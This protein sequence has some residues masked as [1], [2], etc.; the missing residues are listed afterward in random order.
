MSGK[1]ASEFCVT[2]LHQ[3]NSGTFEICWISLRSV[4]CV[5]LVTSW[6]TIPAGAAQVKDT[7]FSRD[8]GFFS[9]PFLVEI[10]TKTSE[11]DIFY[12]LDGSV[13][14]RKNGTRYQTALSI[15]T[16][17]VLRAAA[18]KDG[19]K[20]TNVDTMTYIFPEHVFKQS[21]QGLSST[22]GMRNE[23]PVVA[24][25]GMDAEITQSAVYRDRMLR[26]FESLPIVSLVLDK[27]DWLDAKH[28]I[29]ANPMERGSNWER[30]ASLEMIFP[31]TAND[32]LRQA[33]R[34]FQVN[35]GL[36]IQGG[37]N[38]RPEESP[39]HSLRLL[40]KKKYGPSQLRHPLFS[41]PTSPRDTAEQQKDVKQFK[42][43]IL[44]GGNNNTWLHRSSDERARGDYLRDQ[45]MRDTFAAMGHASARGRFVHLFLNG[46]YWGLYNLT[47]RPSAPWLASH[48]GGSADD[49]DARNSNKVLAG[50]N[51][52]WEALMARVNA[53][54]VSKESYA[55]VCDRLD[56]VN[57]A[58]YMLLNLYGANA[59]YDSS[60]NWYA[61]RPR[62]AGGKFRFFVWDGER[63][64][65]DWKRNAID[66]D[67]P[68]SPPHIFQKLRA[69]PTFRHLFANRAKLHCYGNGVL[70]S[71][72]TAA[73]FSFLAQ[74]IEHAMVIESA[75][76]GDY[77]RDVHSHETGPFELYTVD[78]FWRVEVN[79]LLEEYFPKR[80]GT[81]V[82]QLR[83]AGFE[84]G[85]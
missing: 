44:R 80:T 10:S 77:R 64:N 3:N 18:F 68:N 57:F 79:R 71:H 13:P 39:K 37:W 62:I 9:Q 11:A 78:D 58:D 26:G 76:W 4:S 40:F 1:K 48:F 7:K 24:D 52:A 61:G 32:Q 45:W 50:D 28:G 8:R 59:D 46:Y 15:E 23:K 25:Y 21:G 19:A 27:R 69:W 36:R 82:D 38:R 30:R 53:G 55:A 2:S 20:S 81:L 16:T 63:T 29:Y 74:R 65:E 66:Y 49:Y 12:T 54:I 14:T 67:S 60:S 34:D 31:R 17:S 47:E 56:V 35:C 33:A 83:Q 84:V 70:T 73:R 42:T 22:W 85:E 41:V 43:L 51:V 75:R 72:A 5:L 6:I